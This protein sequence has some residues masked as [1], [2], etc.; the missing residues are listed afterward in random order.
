MAKVLTL[1]GVVCPIGD[2]GIR[3]ALDVLTSLSVTRSYDELERLMF[4]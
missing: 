3:K 2:A 1:P 4:C